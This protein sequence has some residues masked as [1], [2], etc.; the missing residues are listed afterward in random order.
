MI[1]TF[2]PVAAKCTYTHTHIRWLQ[3]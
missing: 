3:I 1:Q 2:T